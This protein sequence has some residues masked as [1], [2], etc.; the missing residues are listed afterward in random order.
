MTLN[1]AL[2]LTTRLLAFAMVLQSVE[3]LSLLRRP[4]FFGIWSYQNLKSDLE[5]HLPLPNNI[6]AKLFSE[7][8]F[9]IV[10]SIQALA[11]I[12]SLFYP[13]FWLFAILF[14]THLTICIRFRGTFNGG[15][16]MMTFI[17]LT[18]VLV[19]T[20]SAS[21]S[22]QKVGLLYI[23]VHALYSYFKAGLVKVLNEEW[24]SGR[25]LPSFLSQSLYVD[26]QKLSLW[27]ANKPSVS[28]ILCW[29]VFLFELSVITTPFFPKHLI[30]FFTIA[31]VFHFNVFIFFGLNRFF[32]M[33][34]SVWP[35]I[36][37]TL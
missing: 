22:V 15:S 27:L 19:S 4:F 24:R 28:K 9:M 2:G 16:D 31:V 35:A 6:I 1:L 30:V 8:T 20:A 23:T 11:A 3:F 25:G 37:Y 7:N 17:L 10:V 13:A 26:I 34:L 18:G 5:S 36:F 32:W 14:F 21:A 12:Y 33:W 29:F